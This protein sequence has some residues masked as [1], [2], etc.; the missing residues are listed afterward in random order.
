M[1]VP[2]GMEMERM[3]VPEGMEMERM[4]VP[5]GTKR[6]RMEVPEGTKRERMEVPEGTKRER[7]EVP[8]GMEMEQQSHHEG[9]FV[10]VIRRVKKVLYGKVE[11]CIQ[12]VGHAFVRP[13]AGHLRDVHRAGGRED[14]EGRTRRTHRSE[15]FVEICSAGAS[16]AD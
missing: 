1:E 15:E 10:R 8:R 9:C 6:E 11:D 14:G 12:L 7:M 4:E 2:E 3:E 13:D 16:P 5:E